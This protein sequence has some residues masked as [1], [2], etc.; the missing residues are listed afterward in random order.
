MENKLQYI[1]A[2]DEYLNDWETKFIKNFVK[3]IE[4][5]EHP[6]TEKQAAKVDTI[7]KNV[8]AEKEG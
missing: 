6:V 8:K 7:Y 4:N 1:V 5:N 3:M 2:N